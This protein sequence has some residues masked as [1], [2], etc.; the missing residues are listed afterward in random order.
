MWYFR[1][2]RSGLQ[3]WNSDAM[4]VV[5]VLHCRTRFAEVNNETHQLLEH[6]ERHHISWSAVVNL[7]VHV[8]TLQG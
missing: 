1:H 6:S 2:D 3:Q 7:R 8:A 5:E 4:V